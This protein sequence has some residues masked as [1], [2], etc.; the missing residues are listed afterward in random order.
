MGGA[1]L[2]PKLEPALVACHPGGRCQ[3]PG[4]RRWLL[5]LPP[6]GLHSS[7][8]NVSIIS[9]CLTLASPHKPFASP[10][11]PAEVLNSRP[12]L[13][14]ISSENFQGIMSD[15][16]AAVWPDQLWRG[17]SMRCLLT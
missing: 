17:S 16:L 14:M 4:S 10:L 12:Q 7:P 3:V 6:M 9:A 5:P 15:S 8:G 13:Q 11:P 2:E 1:S